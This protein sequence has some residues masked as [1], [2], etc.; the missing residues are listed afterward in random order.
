M[1]PKPI[2]WFASFKSQD[3]IPYGSY[4][5]HDL[6]DEI[7]TDCKIETNNIPPFK[8]LYDSSLVNASYII[9]TEKFKPIDVNRNAF[10]DFVKRGNKL[11]V[12]ASVFD[13]KFMQSLNFS[14]QIYFNFV[15]NEDSVRFDKDSVYYNFFNKNHK[16]DLGFYIK[17]P[18]LVSYIDSLDNNN[19][20]KIAYFGREKKISFCRIK[21]GKGEF[22]IDMQPFAY[23]N[24]NVL[25]LNNMQYVLNSFGF[26]Y[27][28]KIIWD[29]YYNN[30]SRNQ[31]A[32]YYIL[33]QPALQ[34]AWYLLLVLTFVYLLFGSKR[35]QKI[36]P[37]IQKKSNTTLEFVV[38]LA[39]LYL[40]NKNHKDIAL[41]KYDY[42]LN[43]LRKQYFLQI[44]KNQ[45]LDI[46]LI[47]EKSGISKPL[48]FK[49]EEFK[50]EIERHKEIS[51]NTLID[52]NGFIDK[53][54]DAVSRSG[55]K[56]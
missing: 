5:V 7:F 51:A 32:M 37:I 9:I 40:S 4:V 54:Y 23:T 36:I 55:I 1:Q 10:F 28:D 21:Y 14:S 12:S 18:I 26:A 48:I 45:A 19:T 16:T 43:F 20:T 52:F 15:F 30:V 34:A 3:K 8:I 41:K 2:D 22:I 46:D 42:W 6:L 56:S 35:K 27:N 38:T 47:S 17:S 29:E 49:I 11:F 24:Y 44:E 25:R 31:S 50:Q 39:N 33:S 13:E 53:F